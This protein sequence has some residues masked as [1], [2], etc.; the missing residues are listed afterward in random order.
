M[1]SCVRLFPLVATGSCDMV[2]E[3]YLLILFICTLIKEFIIS[4]YFEFGCAFRKIE[5]LED[6]S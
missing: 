3:N 6:G 5:A 2:K 4:Q 1:I